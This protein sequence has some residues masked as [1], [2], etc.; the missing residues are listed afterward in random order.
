MIIYLFLG[1]FLFYLLNIFFDIPV[2]Y[3][4]RDLIIETG[5]TTLKYKWLVT[6]L[7]PKKLI[8]KA[9]LKQIQYVDKV[10]VCT[11][12]DSEEE[13]KRSKENLFSNED[14]FNNEVLINNLEQG[15]K[16]INIKEKYFKGKLVFIEDPS[17][18]FVVHTKE[19]NER[20]R[21]ILDYL[22]ENNGIIGINGNGFKKE[23]KK[24][25]NIIGCSL[26]NNDFWCS[27][28]MEDFITI[29]FNSENHLVIG[30]INNYIDYNL[31]D[32]VQFKPI[33]I[34]DGKS[35]IN[36][37][38]G[39]G[40]QP[41]TILGQRRDGVV[42]FLIIDGRKLFY[43]LGCLLEDAANILLKYDVDIAGVCDGG[44][45]TILAY[46]EKIINKPATRYK[47]GRLLPNAIIVKK[48]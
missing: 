19:K 28:N 42:V 2:L 4:F 17:R 3:K 48:R 7:F 18:I 5:I 36:G 35:V 38:G 20:G 44:G 24:G 30:K 11:F 8:D 16:I 14:K 29:G 37:N 40:I 32:F 15:V 43:S 46:D 25:E 31:R 21:F 9:K 23:N 33:L 39:Y 13:I 26:A 45:S 10:G 41:R 6:C 22:N 1:L 34:M 27:N 47:Q 12:F